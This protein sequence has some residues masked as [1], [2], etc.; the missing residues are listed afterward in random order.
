LSHDFDGFITPD[1]LLSNTPVQEADFYLCGPKPFLRSLVPA[2]AKIGVS[3][4]RVHFEF[5]G[6]ADELL[7]A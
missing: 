6:P 3:T 7:A 4:E 5:F 1:W 2:L